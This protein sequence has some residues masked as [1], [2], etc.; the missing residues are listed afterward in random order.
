M[1]K[2]KKRRSAKQVAAAKKNAARMTACGKEFAKKKKNKKFKTAW[3]SFI[4]KSGPR[5]KRC[6]R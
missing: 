2:T 1:S 3:K 5:G 4:K 6:S